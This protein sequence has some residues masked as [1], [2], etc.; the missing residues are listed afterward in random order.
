[1]PLIS[2]IFHE[3]LYNGV[4]VYLDD[5]LIYT[6]TMEGRVTLV[7]QVVK[8]LLATHL[9]VKLSKHEFHKTQLDYL[10]F[11]ITPNG[12]EMDPTKVKAVLDWQNTKTTTKFLGFRQLLPP[13]HFF[14]CPS[15]SVAYWPLDNEAPHQEAMSRLPGSIDDQ[16]PASI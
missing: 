5:T 13:V 16:V 15:S 11:C 7:H 6:K 12:I 9:Y 2:K 10:G 8:K 3:H 4:L 1:M 14:F